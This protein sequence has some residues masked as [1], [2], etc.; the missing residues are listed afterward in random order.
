LFG[1]FVGVSNLNVLEKH[2]YMPEFGWDQ[3]KV[4]E[5]A[6]AGA[7]IGGVCAPTNVTSGFPLADKRQADLPYDCLKATNPLAQYM[8]YA[9]YFAVAAI[10]SVAVFE[11]VRHR[12]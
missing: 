3:P 1:V 11:R 10:I 2:A 9:L 4:V 12:L 8:N 7:P 5:N 6:L